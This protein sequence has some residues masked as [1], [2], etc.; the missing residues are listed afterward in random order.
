MKKDKE[1]SPEEL[2]DIAA[3]LR[4]Y[5]YMFPFSTET[6]LADNAQANSS[7]SFEHGNQIRIKSKELNEN[8]TYDMFFATLG[9]FVKLRKTQPKA[10]SEYRDK[11]TFL[12]DNFA[13]MVLADGSKEE[14]KVGNGNMKMCKRTLLDKLY[15]ITCAHCVHDCQ[16][17]VE[18]SRIANQFEC[19]GR[20]ATDLMLKDDDCKNVD[21]AFIEILSDKIKNCEFK[22]RRPFDVEP[23]SNWKVYTETPVKEGTCVY[24]IGGTVRLSQGIVVQ[25]DTV[26]RLIINE[27]L[28]LRPMFTLLI[29]PLSDCLPGNEGKI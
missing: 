9:C 5:G 16:D 19:F 4:K 1:L 23:T 6:E 7:S 11:N 20:I 28:S 2:E 27:K 22:V 10:N 24:I 3:C 12:S 21:L 14:K 17:M 15:A 29:E 25:A 13:E 26:K 18:V 8:K